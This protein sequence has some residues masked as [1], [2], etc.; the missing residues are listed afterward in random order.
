[1]PIPIVILYSL[2]YSVL[3]GSGEV[4]KIAVELRARGMIERGEGAAP[5]LAVFGHFG[6]PVSVSVTSGQA[7]VDEFDNRHTPLAGL[8]EEAV[9]QKAGGVCLAFREEGDLR[10]RLDA[11]RNHDPGHVVP[12]AG[13]FERV[14]AGKTSAAFRQDFRHGSRRKIVATRPIP[15]TSENRRGANI[16]GP[17]SAL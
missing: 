12:T 17:I 15:P 10:H 13:L 5:R 4:R 2:N 1:M 7:R 14:E 6:V 8:V 11:A 9:E 3:T 16:G